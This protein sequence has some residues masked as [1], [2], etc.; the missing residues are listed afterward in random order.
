MTTDQVVAEARGE[1]E[2]LHNLPVA[3]PDERERF[4]REHVLASPALRRLKQAMDEWCAVWFWPSD[5]QSLQCVP[6]P[7]RFHQPS[8][9]AAKTIE[10]VAAKVKFFHWELEFPDVFTPE[11]S[12][13]DAMNRQSAVGRD[14]AEFSG[15]L[16]GLRSAVSNLR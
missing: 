2:K 12:G 9:Q 13:F 3:D 11:R 5:E 10:H 7:L 4:Y 14:E 8:E 15:V 1:Y 16:H 6:T